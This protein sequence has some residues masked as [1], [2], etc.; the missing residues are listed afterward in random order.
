MLL[1]TIVLIS[2]ITVPL[3][4]VIVDN[5]F[6]WIWAIFVTLYQTTTRVVYYPEL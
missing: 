3:Q 6:Y 4:L 2:P 1:R 5:I